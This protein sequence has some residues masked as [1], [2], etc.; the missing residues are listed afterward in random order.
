MLAYIKAKTRDVTQLSYTLRDTFWVSDHC[1]P[2]MGQANECLMNFFQAIGLFDTKKYKLWQRTRK[3]KIWFALGNTPESNIVS[4]LRSTR[5]HKVTII[6]LVVSLI[7]SPDLKNLSGERLKPD[8]ST[9][10]LRK[11]CNVPFQTKMKNSSTVDNIPQQIRY[12]NLL[13]S[14]F[15]KIIKPQSNKALT[16]NSH[17]AHHYYSQAIYWTT[18]NF[19]SYNREIIAGLLFALV[20]YLTFTQVTIVIQLLDLQRDFHFDCTTNSC[21]GKYQ[22]V[23]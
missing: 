17:F 12:F 16:H 19:Q 10:I 5:S 9:L 21:T 15:A 8:Q 18:R 7:T 3:R 20:S 23:Q 1:L 22:S 14:L 4:W 11:T 13:N 6:C 2:L